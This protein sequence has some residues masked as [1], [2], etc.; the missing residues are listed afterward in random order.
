MFEA[1]KIKKYMLAAVFGA[2][3]LHGGATAHAEDVWVFTNTKTQESVYLDDESVEWT[4]RTSKICSAEVK[5]VK[6]DGS[7]RLA[8]TW[9]FGMDEGFLF[10]S[11]GKVRGYAIAARPQNSGRSTVHHRPDLMAVFD[12]IVED[13]GGSSRYSF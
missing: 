9:T 10:A 3:L 4:P 2:C 12:W 13:N 8:E 1:K 6:A 11:N 7:L 5:W